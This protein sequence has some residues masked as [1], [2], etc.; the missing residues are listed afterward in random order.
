MVFVK[1]GAGHLAFSPN[2][3]RLA[4]SGRIGQV[5]QLLDANT[6]AERQVV[7]APVDF[8]NVAFTAGG[9]RL[10]TVGYSVLMEWALKSHST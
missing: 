9:A 3:R 6:G 4:C 10:I 8:L 5:V 7:K 2:G 1:F